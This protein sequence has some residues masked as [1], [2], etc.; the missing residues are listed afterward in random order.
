MLGIPVA[1]WLFLLCAAGV[2]LLLRRTPYGFC[3]YRLGGNPVATSFSGIPNGRLILQ[4]YLL[5]GLLSGLAGL[6][7]ISRFNSAKADFGESYL[8]IT[9]LAVVL[10]GANPNGG[11][12]RILGL[13]LALFIFQVL[14]SGLNFLRVSPF[15]GIV[16][17]GLIMILVMAINFLL[18]RMKPRRLQPAD[19]G[20]G[21]NRT[22][23]PAAEA[24]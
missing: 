1:F 3:L 8:L 2:G 4:T 19:A 17:W 18:P 11:S 7:M 10:G 21:S 13:V 16:L 6:V 23:P 5:S 14:S 20:P 24:S 12:G 9:I 22:T 15:L